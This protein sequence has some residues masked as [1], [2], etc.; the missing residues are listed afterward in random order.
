MSKI[1]KKIRPPRY[2]L[3]VLPQS[4]N[5][6]TLVDGTTR[7]ATDHIF[8]VGYEGVEFN[9]TNCI[10]AVEARSL[11][12]INGK[13]QLTLVEGLKPSFSLL[14]KFESD[15]EHFT[16]NFV[17]KIDDDSNIQKICSLV[18]HYEDEPEIDEND[19]KLTWEP[20]Q[21]KKPHQDED[22][23][24]ETIQEDEVKLMDSKE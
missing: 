11:R 8:E 17:K 14:I 1:K 20:Q 18:L 7:M 13:K 3:P 12:E 24:E 9:S 22:E 6:Y 23:N 5:V 4:I 16:L 2:A 21:I 15:E 19:T 10:N